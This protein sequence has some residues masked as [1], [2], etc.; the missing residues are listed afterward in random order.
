MEHQKAYERQQAGLVKEIVDIAGEF[1][2]IFAP[3]LAHAL[4]HFWSSLQLPTSRCSRASIRWLQSW[5]LSS[6]GCARLL[7]PTGNMLT[8]SPLDAKSFA[9]ISVNAPI[10]YVKPK[11]LE[12]GSGDCILKASRHPCLEAQDDMTFIPNDVELIRDSAEFITI[13]GPNMGRS[14]P[15]LFHLLQSR[16]DRILDFAHQ[17]E[18]RRTSVRSA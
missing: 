10:P 18:S 8:A 16:S 2:P 6:G 7:L 4:T 3:S 13:T 14:L 12:K 11:V 15:S 5:T 17:V 1:P 9:D